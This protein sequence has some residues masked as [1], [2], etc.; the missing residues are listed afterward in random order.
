MAVERP[1]T[2]DLGELDSDA[3]FDWAR[4]TS[5]RMRTAG[6]Y[7]RR[8]SVSVETLDWPRGLGD[9]AVIDAGREGLLRLE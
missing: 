7:Q 2:A 9:R 8:L 3:R 1:D 5:S 6:Y 4:K